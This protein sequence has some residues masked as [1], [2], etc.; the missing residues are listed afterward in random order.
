[1]DSETKL[2]ILYSLSIGCDVLRNNVRAGDKHLDTG[3]IAQMIAK[4]TT[5]YNDE[6]THEAK[7][8]HDDWHQEVGRW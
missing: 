7:K 8:Y 2:Y 6:L 3:L 1:M 5:I 4:L